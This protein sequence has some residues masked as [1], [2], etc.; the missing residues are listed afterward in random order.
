MTI[1]VAEYK[2]R[3]VKT[4]IVQV[5]EGIEFEIKQISPL[6]FM[7]INKGSEPNTGEQVRMILLN[8]VVKPELSD[9]V[10][11]G[12][13]FIADIK[14]EHLTK[15]V[16]AIMIFSDYMNEDGTPKSFFSNAKKESA[17]TE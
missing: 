16:N 9:K 3:F 13:L 2:D 10:E 5:D 8:G 17:S 14:A 15:L 7:E 11:D 12:K 6:K 1:S 4:K